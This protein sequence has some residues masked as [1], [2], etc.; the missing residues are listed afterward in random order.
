LTNSEESLQIANTLRK[1]LLPQTITVS[2]LSSHLSNLPST[3]IEIPKKVLGSLLS[4]IVPGG[5]AS[6]KLDSTF[7]NKAQI[8]MM[9]AAAEVSY[10][11]KSPERITRS[12]IITVMGH[13]DHGKTTLIDTLRH[14]DI[15]A[16]EYGSITQSIGAFSLRMNRNEYVTVIDTPGH[17][18]FTEM[19]VR[20]VLA[21]DIV[22][23]VVSAIEGVQRQTKEVINL[24]KDS[25]VP[26]IIA[27]N[28]IDRSEADPDQIL[29]ELAEYDIIA[30]ELG[31]TVPSVAISAKKG[32]NIDKLL[33]TLKAKIGTLRLEESSKVKGQGFIIESEMVKSKKFTGVASS[34][35]IMRGTLANDDYFICDQT[36]GRVKHIRDDTKNFVKKIGG[37]KAAHISGF[38]EIPIPGSLLYVVEN[39]RQALIIQILKKK[40]KSSRESNVVQESKNFSEITDSVPVLIKA[41]RA[42]ILETIENNMK[43][44]LKTGAIRIISKEIGPITE[45]DIKSINAMKGLI[46]G[47]EVDCNEDALGAALA[48][49][50]PIRMHKLMLQLMDNLEN[51]ENEVNLRRGNLFND[52]MLGKAIVK[53][54]FSLS[55]NKIIAAGS[56]VTVGSITKERKCKVI[57]NGEVVGEDLEVSGLKIVSSNVNS[58]SEGSECG[59]TL[60]QFNNLKVG[61][62]I[63]SYI[64]VKRPS[65]FSFTPGIKYCD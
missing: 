6:D 8:E 23:L 15:A 42:G 63:E 21:T 25:N 26:V 39:E 3:F 53:K 12:P 33:E 31:G 27:V 22:I 19:R 20:G 46:F 10:D 36:M 61:D 34:V 5:I 28:K 38:K 18:I 50:V 4:G 41:S 62:T 55:G 13:V 58:V 11:F 16:G 14:S 24:I 45:S 44:R 35:V 64:K 37:G 9:C 51:L 47:F 49:G 43:K 17:E 32:D 57:R 54:L 7:L 1:L 52:V 56:Q 65:T 2:E 29:L 40:L 59:I 30:E 60:N 48:Y